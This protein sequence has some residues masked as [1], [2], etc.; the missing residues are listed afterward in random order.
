MAEEEVRP[1]V[2]FGDNVF[3]RIFS[4]GNVYLDRRGRRVRRITLRMATQTLADYGINIDKEGVTEKGRPGGRLLVREY[5]EVYI[6]PLRNAKVGGKN[7]SIIK[8]RCGFDGSENTEDIMAMKGYTEDIKL[9][10]QQLT[11]IR[12]L[13]VG[14]AQENAE[15][16]TQS[17]QHITDINRLKLA[18]EGKK[19]DKEKEETEDKDFG[20]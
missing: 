2:Q 19:E 1:I 9:L 5:P 12:G 10:E 15:L 11:S 13:M 8:I 16:R 4:L 6:A 17:M 7:E 20:N 3:G 18:L 14:V